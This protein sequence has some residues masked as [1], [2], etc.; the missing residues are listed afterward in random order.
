MTLRLV[1]TVTGGLPSGRLPVMCGQSKSELHN[2][3]RLYW[4]KL[5]FEL[6]MRRL[7]LL[8]KKRWFLCMGKPPCNRLK[9]PWREI[10][11][12][13]HGWMRWRKIYSISFII[14]LI[15]W[16]I[17]AE[18][19]AR[20]VCILKWISSI[21]RLSFLIGYSLSIV[22]HSLVLQINSSVIQL[23]LIVN[24]TQTLMKILKTS[25]TTFKWIEV[26]N[27][28]HEPMNIT[29]WSS[30]RVGVSLLIEISYF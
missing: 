15:K 10:Q 14:K 13:H 17:L 1:F 6:L 9:V 28:L 29:H 3:T 21:G 23:E 27:C 22:D 2:S 18:S 19:L 4:Y 16:D 7:K 25:S 30:S 8:F 5:I 20:I 26:P 11:S 12:L 24:F